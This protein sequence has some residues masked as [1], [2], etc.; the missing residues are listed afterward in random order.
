MTPRILQDAVREAWASVPA[1]PVDDLKYFAWGWGE[2]AAEAFVGVA[3]VDVDIES[4]GFYA[5]TPLL[6]LPPRA[7]AAYLCPFLLSLLEG[8]EFQLK[9]GIFT[10]L[11]SRAHTLA[12]LMMRNFW[13]D[14]IRP[15]LP[16]RCREVL[17][18]VVAL[19][20]AEREALG[21]RPE[22]AA[23]MIALASEP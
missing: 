13:T 20:A 23:A 2:E 12:C 3:P 10:D 18:Q 17:T 9:V 11:L 22:Q 19:L 15:F 8:L 5:A 4:A 1:P 6:D 21:L 7:A 16:P 14:A